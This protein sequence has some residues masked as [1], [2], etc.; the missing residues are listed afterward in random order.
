MASR[1]RGLLTALLCTAMLLASCSSEGSSDESEIVVGLESE[2]TGWLPGRHLLINYPSLNVAYTIFDPLMRKDANAEVRPYLA[3]SM[4]PN[5]DLTQWTLT[6]RP[7][8]L[9]HDGVDDGVRK[10]GR[11]RTGRDGS[12]YPSLPFC[13]DA[14]DDRLL[15]T[16]EVVVVGPGRDAG[17]LRDVVDAKVVQAALQC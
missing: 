15:A 7:G 8:V 16:R 9:F 17:R 11:R 5:A 13:G 12:R 4:E 3:E 14:G 2:T 6:L 1:S 10:V